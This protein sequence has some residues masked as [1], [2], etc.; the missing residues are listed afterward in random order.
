MTSFR[1][2]LLLKLAS[3]MRSGCRASPSSSHQYQS[4]R[5]LPVCSVQTN[6]SSSAVPSDFTR[7]LSQIL[8]S[9]LKKP[10]DSISVSLS[11]GLTMSRGGSDSATMTVEIW[12]IGVFDADRNLNYTKDVFHFLTDTLSLPPNRIVLLFHPLL[13]EEA[14]HLIYRDLQQTQQSSS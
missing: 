6:L 11:T 14:G 12:S 7:R 1:S 8:A 13:K 9:T 5:F 10:E 2:G 4:V 3:R